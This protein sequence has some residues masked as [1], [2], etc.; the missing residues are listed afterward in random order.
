MGKFFK[1]LIRKSEFTKELNFF[2]KNDTRFDIKKQD[3]QPCLDDKTENTGFDTH[4]VYH[5]AWA[6]RTLKKINPSKH[7]DISSY[8]YFNTMA[9]AFFDIDFYDF[10]PA[11]IKLSGLT[12]KAG[13]ITKLPLSDESIDSVSCMHV[14]EHV[15]LGRYGDDLDVDGDLKAIKEL[16]RVL[17]KGGDLLFVVPI[18]ANKRLKFNA[19]RIYTVEMILEYF[20]SLELVEFTLIPD[21]AIDAGMITEPSQEILSK[22]RYG[23]GCFW[24]KK[25]N[26]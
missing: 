8:V 6:I 22:Q 13:D 26:I 15:G 11:K 2:L 17:A 4:Y 16:I 23:C 1:R 9:S 19:H 24:F 12:P 10:R 5:T 18:G 3:L 7:I 20:K 21:N 14:V 25:E